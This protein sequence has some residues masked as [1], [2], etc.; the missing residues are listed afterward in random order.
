MALPAK[1]LGLAAVAVTAWLLVQLSAHL[2]SRLAEKAS[3]QAIYAKAQQ[4]QRRTLAE[5]LALQH[6]K[7]T[8]VRYYVELEAAQVAQDNSVLHGIAALKSA[9]CKLGLLTTVMTRGW[10]L[11]T[12]HKPGALELQVRTLW[13]PV[14]GVTDL[15]NWGG[16]S[17]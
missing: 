3:W 15:S 10:D 16:L 7:R 4:G 8:D 11:L 14:L 5:A 12:R 1:K 2:S 9:S 13:L 17:G 6:L